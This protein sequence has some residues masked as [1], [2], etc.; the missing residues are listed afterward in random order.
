MHASRPVQHPFRP[1]AAARRLCA[2]AGAVLGLL[3]P[4]A[5]CASSNDSAP[6]TTTGSE[7]VR[8]L[9]SATFRVG[10]AP[11]GVAVDR[12]RVWV[13]DAAR[14]TL[15]AIDAASGD[16]LSQLSTGAL[17]PRD[18]GLALDAG[19][20][21]VANLGGTIGVIDTATGQQIARVVTGG[22]EPAAVALDDRWAWVPTHG[23]G[24]GLV[25]L[26]RDDPARQPLTVE[27]SESAFAAAVTG[28]VVWVA[29]LDSRVFA[30]DATTGE[31]KQSIEIG[32]SPR[33]VA[34]AAGDVWVTLRD[35][36]AIVRLDATTGNEVA[37][38]DTGGRPWPIAAG[39]E[40]LWAATVEG[41]LLRL[42]ATRNVINGRARVPPEPRGI[43]VDDKTVWV[44][45]QTGAIAR[46]AAT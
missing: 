28:E 40:V 32:G 39:G 15:L 18:A 38:I 14:A 7:P 20:L 13:S 41:E 24:G 34:I 26:D 42:D 3:L 45:S 44:A 37:R 36:H 5:G 21:W 43:A 22:G 10:G 29:G 16:V 17:D 6:G 2:A 9:A 4:A 23:P 1:C 33:G 46:V 12:Q 25:R 8:E 31:V 35:D 19:Q 11:W 30:I 27:L